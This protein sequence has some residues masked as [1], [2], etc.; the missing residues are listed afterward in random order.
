[1]NFRHNTVAEQHRDGGFVLVNKLAHALQNSA[2]P[3]TPLTVLEL[4]CGT[5]LIGLTLAIL[6]Q[7]SRVTLTDLAEASD[8]IGRN[9]ASNK[10]AAGSSVDF[11]VLKWADYPPW[12]RTY[13]LVVVGDCTYNP[14][15]SQDLLD[16]LDYVTGRE[17]LVI[18]A[19][20][21]RHEAEK[22]FDDLLLRSDLVEKNTQRIFLENEV[23]CPDEEVYIRT[24]VNAEVA[25][26]CQYPKWIVGHPLQSFT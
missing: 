18:I 5:G 17:T 21:I 23:G 24:F 25:K 3:A 10:Y 12:L 1:M 6:L 13:D 26:Q 7:N 16:C 14:D 8:L 2:R 19:T 11:Q 15:Y 20:K 22:D 9:I 4:G